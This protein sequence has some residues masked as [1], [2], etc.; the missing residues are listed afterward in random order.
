MA[1]LP[2][3]FPMTFL[4]ESPPVPTMWRFGVWGDFPKVRNIRRCSQEFLFEISSCL[5]TTEVF[6]V[7]T[8]RPG[9]SMSTSKTSFLLYSI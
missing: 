3:G 6:D 4:S 8:D 1:A 9:R 2:G 5:K 7:N